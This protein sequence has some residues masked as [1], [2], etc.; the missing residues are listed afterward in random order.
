M[1]V[2]P[3]TKH[4]VKFHSFNDKVA[5]YFLDEGCKVVPLYERDGV[6]CYEIILRGRKQ[7]SLV[8]TDDYA[9]LI[10]GTVMDI[11]SVV[12]RRV[13]PPIYTIELDDSLILA[14]NVLLLSRDA[15]LLI[16]SLTPPGEQTCPVSTRLLSSKKDLEDTVTEA[17]ALGCDTVKVLIGYGFNAPKP[18]QEVYKLSLISAFALAPVKKGPDVPEHQDP[19]N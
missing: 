16:T 3:I 1:S 8:K 7:C 15:E 4:L 10:A 17:K 19:N 14:E 11:Y 5:K 13:Q 12:P 18:F 9:K 6:N 2:I